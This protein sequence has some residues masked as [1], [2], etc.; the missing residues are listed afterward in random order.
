MKR[1][2]KEWEKTVT[3][4]MVAKKKKKRKRFNTQNTQD[5]IQLIVKTNKKL[6]NTN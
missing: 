3:N 6:K 2:S 1:Q 4:H 5:A